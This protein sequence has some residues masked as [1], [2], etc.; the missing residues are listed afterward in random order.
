MKIRNGFISNSSSSSFVLVG[1]KLPLPTT[2]DLEVK[3]RLL[4]YAGSSLPTMVTDEN[5]RAGLRQTDFNQSVFE[6]V[7]SI[8]RRGR[9]CK[10]CPSIRLG[11]PASGGDTGVANGYMLLGIESEDEE[12]DLQQALL[13]LDKL[14]N[15]LSIP[16][17]NRVCIFGDTAE[18]DT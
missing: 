1:W 18:N 14:R 6:A 7:A 8:R 5:D 2:A 13:D 15:L 9:L 3:L 17:G 16:V 4:G 12:L 10:N 11:I